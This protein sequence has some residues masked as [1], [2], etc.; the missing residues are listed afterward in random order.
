MKNLPLIIYI[1]F[2]SFVFAQNSNPDFESGFELHSKSFTDGGEIPLQF[3]CKGEN[4]SPELYFS[5]IPAKAKSFLIICED[6]DLSGGFVH[7]FIY[8]IPTNLD[9]LIAGTDF[10]A[11]GYS[12]I[13]I[14]ENDFGNVKYEGPCS[15]SGIHHYQFKVKALNSFVPD[16]YPENIR[17]KVLNYAQ[18]HTVGEAELIGTVTV[19]K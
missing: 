17:Q 9:T 5:N 4:I 11:L 13:K 7:W 8:N 2:S 19:K 14:L 6:T 1:F 18:R 15:S 12:G 10:S 3:T 16:Y